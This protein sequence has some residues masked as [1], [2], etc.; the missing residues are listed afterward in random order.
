MYGVNTQGGTA[1]FGNVYQLSKVGNGWIETPIYSFQGQLDGAYPTAGVIVD[2]DGN[3]FGTTAEG[4]SHG[5]GTVYKL[6]HVNGTWTETVLYS[7]QNSLSTCDGQGPTGLTMDIS[8]N[9]YGSSN[10]NGMN[11][12]TG[13]S[14]FKL[15]RSGDTYS[16]RVLYSTE[17]GAYQCGPEANLTLDANGSIYGTTE[18]GGNFGKGSVFKV[19]FN[20]VD[21]GYTSLHD[22]NGTDGLAAGESGVTF[23]P[24]GTLYGT[25]RLGGLQNKGTVWM[26]KP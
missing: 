7:F 4:G 16:F 17:H 14:V 5:Y 21:W 1:N 25:T 18:C 13:W 11:W 9:L 2:S 23:A 10:V 20:G 15:A 22:F 19:A 3:L 26:I 6:A 12:C 24:D 8:G